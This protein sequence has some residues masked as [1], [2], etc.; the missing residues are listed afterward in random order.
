M[1]IVYHFEPVESVNTNVHVVYM[2]VHVFELYLKKLMTWHGNV[3]V[4]KERGNG[5]F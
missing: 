1:S 3:E 4:R 5:N 2:S